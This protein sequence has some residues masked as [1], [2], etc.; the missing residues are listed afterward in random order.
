MG[1]GFILRLMKVVA[2]GGRGVLVLGSGMFLLYPNPTL[3]NAILR[4]DND[5]FY[6]PIDNIV[7]KQEI[8]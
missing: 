4:L 1:T 8:W 6:V 7:L 3:P 2:M 5:E